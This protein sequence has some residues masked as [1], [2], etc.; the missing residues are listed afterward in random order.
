MIE[1]NRFIYE[2]GPFRLDANKRVLTKEGEPVKLFP[3]EFDTLV[4]LIQHSG[5]VID[6]DELMQ[7]VWGDTIVEESNLTTNISHLRKLL[8]ENLGRNDY[9]VTVPGKGYRFVAG[10]K[11]IGEGGEELILAQRT[12]TTIT[13]Q[14]EEESA[15]APKSL[16][17]LPFKPLR[18]SDRDEYLELGIADALIT[19]LSN[20]R[21]I[22]VR[23]TSSVS[24]Y[25]A[26][27][28]DPLA[29]GRELE[30]EAVLDG[31]VQRAGD[32]VRVTARLLG[33]GDG[34]P[35]WGDKFDAQFTDIFSVQDSI[36]EKIA[37]ALAPELAGR[38][39]LL[40]TKRYTRNAKA[41]Q[42]YLKGRYN[43][44]KPTEE[45]LRKAIDF[46]NQA[47]TVD[48]TYALA[49]VGIAEAYTSLD[50]YG[51]L[52]TKQSNPHAKAAAERALQLDDTLAEAHASLAM[53]RQY[54]WDWVGAEEEYRRAIRLNPNYAAARQW[55]GI[56]LAYTGRFDEGLEQMWRAQ[57]LD[58]VSLAISAQT[59]LVLMFARRYD[60]AL[61]QCM[62]TLEVEPTAVEARLYLAMTYA[63]QQ[64][65]SEAIGEYR[66]LPGDNPDFKAMLGHAY[67][68]SGRRA[69]AQGIL[70]ELE[71]LFGQRY[72]PHFWLS[73][74]HVG[75]G[76]YG[77]ALSCLERACDDPDDSLLSARV[78]PFLDPIRPSPRFDELLR[79]MRFK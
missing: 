36:S 28:Q 16:A 65:F 2:F 63:L 24:K 59:G 69:E 40:L 56:F 57:E 12:R 66:N 62:E 13:I 32:H 14:E 74:I 43:L 37:A 47:I 52:S 25:A 23:P 31:S 58:P 67:A 76:D 68:A 70:G 38:E 49:Y 19:T 27:G 5:V 20:S 18:A 33:V 42:L 60:E 3:K 55:Y 10:V 8:G 75:W 50:W 1:Q 21:G 51:V 41:Y 9:I 7:Q 35:L 79:R 45:G 15:P 54:E 78:M 77:E 73:M 29:A 53:A 61:E 71:A 6:K 11:E 44:N 46:F 4:A 48:P 30:V 64:R 34:A 39:K 26:V 17:V 72:V 22:V